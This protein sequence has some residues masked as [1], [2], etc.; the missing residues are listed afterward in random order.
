MSFKHIQKHKVHMEFTLNLDPNFINQYWEKEGLECYTLLNEAS[1][2]ETWTLTNEPIFQAK[3]QEFVSIYKTAP[4]LQW[5]NNSDKITELMTYMNISQFA[6][7]FRYL[8]I[9]FPGLS[10]HFVME[11]RDKEDWRAGELLLRR[12][13]LLKEYGFL[14]K[15]FS[16]MRTRLISGLLESDN[17]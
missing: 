3:L 6:L 12:I 10:F 9:T 16:P 1:K 15:I 2:L 17:D 7:F 13:K 8:D 4:S 11:A 14:N 5:S